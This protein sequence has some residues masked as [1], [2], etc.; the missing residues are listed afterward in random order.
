MANSFWD[1]DLLFGFYI[2]NSWAPTPLTGIFYSLTCA[3]AFLALHLDN[4][5]TL[6]IVRISSSW[7]GLAFRRRCS[8]LTLWA[9]ANTTDSFFWDIEGSSCSLHWFKKIYIYCSKDILPFSRSMRLLWIHSKEIS[10]IAEDIISCLLIPKI[11]S[12]SSTERIFLSTILVLFIACE[13]Y[14][15]INWSFLVIW[16]CL[17]CIANFSKF[18]FCIFRWIL[19]RMPFLC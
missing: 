9:I 7:T 5:R 2:L 19:I 3:F 12:K 10:K 16:K 4:H 6:P 8:W 13:S 15:I 18:F 14:L 1:L 17:I 11:L